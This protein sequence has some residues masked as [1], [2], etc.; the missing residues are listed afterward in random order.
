ME[1]IKEL[2]VFFFIVNLF[3]EII[4]VILVIFISF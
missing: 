1:L 2:R 4:L 3:V